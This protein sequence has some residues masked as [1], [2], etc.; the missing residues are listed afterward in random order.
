M[1]LVG[2]QRILQNAADSPKTRATESV[3]KKTTNSSENTQVSGPSVLPAPWMADLPDFT[4]EQW[5]WVLH[6]AEELALSKDYRPT[7]TL[8]DGL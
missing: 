3:S 2:W 6:R 5:A 8:I 4:A 1:P 7:R